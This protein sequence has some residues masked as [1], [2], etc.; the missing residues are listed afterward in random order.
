MKRYK[1]LCLTDHLKHS[2]ENSLYALAQEMLKHEYFLEIYVASRSKAE[3]QSFFCG[4]EMERVHALQVTNEF[5]F[6]SSRVGLIDFTENVSVSDFDIVFLRLPQPMSIPFLNSLE[7]SFDGSIVNSPSGIIHCGTK[8]IL[9]NF[10]NL[11]PAMK[12]CHSVQDVLDFC[13]NQDIVLKP[14]REYGGNGLLRVMNGVVNDGK[15]DHILNDY[16]STIEER[17]ESD[18]YLAMEYLKNVSLG[19]KRLIVVDGEIL[20]ASLRLPAQESWLCNVALGGTSILSSPDEDEEQI[21]RTIN[22]FLKEQGILI[23]GVDT[24]VD[25]NGKRVLSEI[26]VS[27]IGGFPQAEKQTGKP[28]IKRTLDKIIEYVK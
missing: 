17:L 21:V 16:L 4:E 19:D 26:N 18:G 1:V 20:A 12:L 25:N 9:L 13:S 8:E 24:L 27:S 15:K 7:Q 5:S 3:N 6:E 22:P 2:K 23:Y 11:C 10:S 14:L 28:I